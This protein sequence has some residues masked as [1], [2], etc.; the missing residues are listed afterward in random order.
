MLWELSEDTAEAT[1]LRA[2]HTALWARFRRVEPSATE[3][4]SR[5]ADLHP[6]P[7]AVSRWEGAGAR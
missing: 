4:T 6:H 7:D 5:P 1:L 2:A 3:S